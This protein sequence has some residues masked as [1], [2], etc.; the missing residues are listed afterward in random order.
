MEELNI[1]TYICGQFQF[2]M[3]S[4]IFHFCHI[5]LIKI[6]FSRT[7]NWKKFLVRETKVKI[8]EKLRNKKPRILGV[9]WLIL[10]INQNQ[11]TKKC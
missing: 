7:G 3:R 4:I 5:Y 1:H 11:L 10:A 9:Q 6:L 2:S 8:A